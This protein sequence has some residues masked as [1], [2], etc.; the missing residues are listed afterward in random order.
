MDG[1]VPYRHRKRRAPV[2]RARCTRPDVVAFSCGAPRVTGVAV[3]RLSL[4]QR[5]AR[6]RPAREP[7][8]F[9]RSGA[10]HDRCARSGVRPREPVQG[11]SVLLAIRRAHRFLHESGRQQ[12]VVRHSFSCRWHQNCEADREGV[13][14]FSRSRTRYDRRA[15]APRDS[16]VGPRPGREHG[17]PDGLPSPRQ[18]MTELLQHARE[19]TVRRAL[20]LGV[21]AM[22]RHPLLSIMLLIAT[23]SQGFLQGMLVWALRKVLLLFSNEMHRDAG[24]LVW[25]AIAIFGI[26]LLRVFTTYLGQQAS[27]RLAHHVEI[28]EMQSV[29]AKFMTLSVRSI[30]RNSQGEMVLSTYEDV[31]G[32][33]Q[34]TLAL[35]TIVLSLSRLAGLAVVCWVISPKLAIV[36]LI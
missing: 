18:P 13:R 36:G 26:W 19:Y 9:P 16:A 1:C 2:Q 25:G 7:G 22:R 27:V 6:A 15:R 24:T 21:R 33:R 32:I 17:E 4:E 8:S 31:K 5:H 28:G 23:L 29:L 20:M 34:V 3:S 30:E 14:H 11:R 10:A 12:G 35:G